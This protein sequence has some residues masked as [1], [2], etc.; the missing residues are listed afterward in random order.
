MAQ[1]A[2]NTFQKQQKASGSLVNSVKIRL[3]K[4][5]YFPVAI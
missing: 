1:N 3:E 4:L 2:K 5:F